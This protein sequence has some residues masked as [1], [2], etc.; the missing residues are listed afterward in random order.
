MTR[1]ISPQ[2][3]SRGKKFVSDCC[4]K[5]LTNSQFHTQTLT[6]PVDCWRGSRRMQLC[7]VFPTERQYFTA[8]GRP[9]V[10]LAHTG[11]RRKEVKLLSQLATISSFLLSFWKQIPSLII[12]Y[13]FWI[14]D[15]MLMLHSE[16]IWHKELNWN[17]PASVWKVNLFWVFHRKKLQQIYSWAWFSGEICTIAK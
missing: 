10:G 4:F 11:A 8:L 3:W 13:S 7:C 1:V 6:S 14:Q 16:F 17:R 5:V 15:L 9:R 2:T 12:L